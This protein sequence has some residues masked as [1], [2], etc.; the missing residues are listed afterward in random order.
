MFESYGSAS[1]NTEGRKPTYSII[2]TAFTPA[3]TATDYFTL[4]NPAASNKICRVETVR[5]WATATAATSVDFYYYKRTTAN[6]GGTTTALTNNICYHDSNNPAPSGVPVSYSANPSSTGTGTVIRA[7]HAYVGSTAAQLSVTDYFYGVRNGQA[8]VLRPGELFA[9]NFNGASV[10]SGLSIFL[11]V[12][13][14]EEV[15]SYT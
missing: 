14:T 11:E 8:L 7:N 13:W 9:A 12:E 3:A 5:I 10:P 6:S 4:S 1:V 15:L 2:L